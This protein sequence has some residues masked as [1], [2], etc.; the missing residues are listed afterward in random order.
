M[1]AFWHEA[2]KRDR[3]V[4]RRNEVPP[5]AS[6]GRGPDLAGVPEIDHRVGEGLERVVHPADA[7]EAQ[8]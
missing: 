6:S 1:A 4:P 8:Q 2:G 7:L 5:V 3:G